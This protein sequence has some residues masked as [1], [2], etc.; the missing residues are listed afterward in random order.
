MINSAGQNWIVRFVK[1]DSP[2]FLDRIELNTKE[3]GFQGLI[4]ISPPLPL[5]TQKSVGEVF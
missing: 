4:D 2:V 3:L 1:L 5:S